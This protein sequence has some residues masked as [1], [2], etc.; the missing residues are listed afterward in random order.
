MSKRSTIQV[1]YDLSDVLEILRAAQ[2]KKLYD[3][4]R[5][6]LSD[7]DDFLYSGRFRSVLGLDGFKI[8]KS[9]LKELIARV[10]DDEVGANIINLDKM[11]EILLDSGVYYV[12]EYLPEDLA[13]LKTD[14]RW[15]TAYRYIAKHFPDISFADF[16]IVVS[17]FKDTMGH[18]M[19][20][21]SSDPDL[22][23]AMGEDSKLFEIVVD[24][25]S[26]LMQMSLRQLREICEK[27]GVDSAR[28]IEETADRIVENCG[29]RALQYIPE[30][31]KGRR[32]LII[33]DQELAT[34]DD[35]LR[36]DSYLRAMS[37]VVREDLVQFVIRR[38]QSQWFPQP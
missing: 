6:K 38:R 22:L 11:F 10:N 32:S 15:L 1:A 30:E 24:V 16:R 35:I 19:Y 14:E 37:K 27:E 25:K 23:R 28:S 5:I 36:L 18:S 13:F 17:R 20:V 4:R 8:F 29:E 33:K 9:K 26:T 34:G 2:N 3:S 12:E 7:I 21:E 31:F